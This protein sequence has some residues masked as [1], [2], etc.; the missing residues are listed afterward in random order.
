MSKVFFCNSGAE[1]NE[2]AIKLARKYSRDKYG[3]G[4]PG[5]TRATIITLK[6]S[7]H[8][9]TITTLAATGQDKFHLDFAP[10]TEG[11]KYVPPNDIDA[12]R[13]AMTPDVCGF[14]DRDNTGRGR[15]QLPARSISAR[16]RGTLQRVRRCAH[17]RR[18]ADWHRAYRALSHLPKLWHR[19]GYN[20]TCQGFG[21]RASIGA[22]L[23][24]ERYASVLGPGDH[25]STFGG[26]PSPV[27][28]R[29]RS[30]AG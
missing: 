28:A 6:N 18:G 11:F 5:N 30:C 16:R 8:G 21:R 14:D 25:G 2:G 4:K 12:L 3:F 9:R 23:C 17:R 26:N 13:E 10:Y 19:A 29:S 1:A 27:P 7:F 15:R 24:N 20:H 22:F